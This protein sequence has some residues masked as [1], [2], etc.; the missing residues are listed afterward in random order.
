MLR[1]SDIEPVPMTDDLLP[2]RR[3]M[4]AQ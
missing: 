3:F 1:A 4:L 2:A